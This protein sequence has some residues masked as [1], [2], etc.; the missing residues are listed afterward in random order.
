[1]ETMEEKLNSCHQSLLMEY[2][3][4]KEK[5]LQQ[6]QTTSDFN[7]WSYQ[8]GRRESALHALTQFELRFI[9]DEERAVNGLRGNYEI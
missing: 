4:A 8:N 2:E 5:A 9:K 1:M 7:E 6:L 3:D